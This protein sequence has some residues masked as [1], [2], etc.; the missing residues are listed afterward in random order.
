MDESFE[1]ILNPTKLS[2]FVLS[3]FIEKKILCV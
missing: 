1:N 2:T 3:L